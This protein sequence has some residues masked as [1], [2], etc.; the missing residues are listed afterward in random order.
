MPH[1]ILLKMCEINMI[2]PIIELPNIIVPTVPITNSGPL[3]VQK[4]A[5]FF[6]SACVMLPLLYKSLI[7]LAPTG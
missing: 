4:A 6:A 2:I 7:I 5:I 3:V 1:K